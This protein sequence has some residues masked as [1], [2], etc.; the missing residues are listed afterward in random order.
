M[1]RNLLTHDIDMSQT[2]LTTLIQH[3]A[4]NG[5]PTSVG[6]E[7]LTI[8]GFNGA[9]I[10]SYYPLVGG[11]SEKSQVF[12]AEV[13]EN[14]G[15]LARAIVKVPAE[16][17][18]DRESEAASGV[19]ARELE[20][21]NLL[22]DMQGGFQPHIFAALYDP[23]SQTTALL[24]ED[25]GEL[26]KRGEFIP[27]SIRRVLADL[28]QIHSRYW[29]DESLS[30]NWWMRD[31]RRADIF[32]EDVEQF[33]PNWEKL[34]TSKVLCPLDT[35]TVNEVADFLADNILEVLQELD[36]RPRTL[37]HGD[38]HTANM[39]LRRTDDPPAPVL[40]DWQDAV[41]SGAS[42]DVAK[43]LSTTLSPED[44]RNRFN[45]L[46]ADYYS[47]LWNDI[48]SDYSFSA[49]RRDI[50][51]ALL[52]TFANYVICATTSCS[53]DVDPQSLNSSLRRVSSVIDVVR[54]L[55]EL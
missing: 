14:G 55:D 33:A 35:A 21:Y 23:E 40:I 15:A 30:G 13:A 54:P 51:L 6:E 31:G 1:R 26:P 10:K 25:L 48:R 27:K 46:V 49:F 29:G 37:T 20:V 28:A 45:R 18:T 22:R 38:L 7:L 8:A 47:A 5:D 16:L 3:A 12:R 2:Q 32:D 42:S 41:Y 36:D 52:G 4:E 24:I 34:A 19:Y 11:N 44:A 50:M 39:M 53:S 9:M 43:F 17:S